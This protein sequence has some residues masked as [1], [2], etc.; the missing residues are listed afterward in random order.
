MDSNDSNDT[1][2]EMDSRYFDPMQHELVPIKWYMWL[3]MWILPTYVAYE[4]D[5]RGPG[6][7][8]LYYKYWKDVVYYVREGQVERDGHGGTMQALLEI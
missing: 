5:V 3:W 4:N 6:A 8:I 1:K 2:I 7:I